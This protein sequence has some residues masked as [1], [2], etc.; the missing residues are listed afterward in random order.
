MTKQNGAEP[1][2]SEI[3]YYMMIVEFDMLWNR[4]TTA[5]EQLRMEHMIGLINAF[6]AGH[7]FLIPQMQVQ[8]GLGLES[9]NKEGPTTM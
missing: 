9:R 2:I 8:T 4:N 3:E 1:L 7:T 6:E 5:Q